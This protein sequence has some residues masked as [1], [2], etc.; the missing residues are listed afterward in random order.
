MPFAQ[1]WPRPHRAAPGSWLIP[2]NHQSISATGIKGL[3]SLL[4][5][6]DRHEED[7]TGRYGQK[8]K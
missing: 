3:T 8:K 4:N 2:A 6:L 1:L 5:Q 7:Q